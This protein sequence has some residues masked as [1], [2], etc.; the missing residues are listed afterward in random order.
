MGGGGEGMAVG[1]RH[2]IALPLGTA[3]V[4][5]KSNEEEEVEGFLFSKLK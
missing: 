4:V 1:Q 2:N 3:P 5:S